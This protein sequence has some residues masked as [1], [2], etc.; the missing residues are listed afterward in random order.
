MLKDLVA[1]GRQLF[2]LARK[3]QEHE[4]D[5]KE[6]REDLKDVRVKFDELAFEV[7]QLALELRHQRAEAEK[8]REILMLRLENALLKH[9][10]A[11][12]PGPSES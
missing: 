4:A 12:P 9:D 5:I 1:F 11:L 3:S 6:L 10:R 2:A 7:K 8:D